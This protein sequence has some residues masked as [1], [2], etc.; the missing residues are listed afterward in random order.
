MTIYENEEQI[1]K[2]I[3]IYLEEKKNYADD[4]VD[5]Y[6]E[7][8]I[9]GKHAAVTLTDIAYDK[10]IVRMYAEKEKIKKEI[11]TIYTSTAR[12]NQLMEDLVLVQ[13]DMI[14]L[15][16]RSTCRHQGGNYTTCLEIEQAERIF[17]ER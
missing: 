11:A 5:D 8:D 16:D 17:S 2:G 14:H 15:L 12:M 9:C 1:E 10:L 4:N 7:V 6:Y 3:S 13:L